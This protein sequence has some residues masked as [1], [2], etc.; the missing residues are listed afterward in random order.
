MSGN[1]GRGCPMAEQTVGWALHALEPDEEMAAAE[2]LAHCAECR[3][4]AD[5]V[6]GV[7]SGLATALPQY[8]PPPGLRDAI[9]EQ[10]R[11]TPQAEPAEERT[12]PEIPADRIA[13]AA[14]APQDD[15]PRSDAPRAD[16]PHV[17]GPHDDMPRGRHAAKPRRTPGPAPRR[18]N[19]GPG[20][21]RPRRGGRLLVAGAAVL[22]L[23]VGGGILVNQVQ[24]LRSE[25][26]ATL[27]QA[28][29]AQEQS[30]RM[31]DVLGQM[32]QPGSEHAFLRGDGGNG[33]T[34]AALVVRDGTRE[35]VPMGMPP[36]RTD[37]Q[38]YVLWGIGNGAA[39]PTPIGTFDVASGTSGP[40]SVASSGSG[41]FAQYAVSLER[42]RVAP[43][44]PT[45]VVA[46][47]Q[48]QT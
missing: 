19:N 44:A 38:T 36:N 48:V 30:R 28:Q 22:A 10:A 21:A 39:Q 29:Q 1:E 42:G 6:A 33:A 31:Q 45:D 5:D 8:E 2:H 9:V 23:L 3:R 46:A 25:R 7:T 47:G 27:A 14:A 12:L 24:G 16:A 4:I 17:A 35:L 41:A 20:R 34:M 37:D 43:A 32:A 13:P 11:R 26:D 18:E 15:A 40:I